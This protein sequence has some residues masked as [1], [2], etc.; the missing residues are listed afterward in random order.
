MKQRSKNWKYHRKQIYIRFVHTD[1]AK[2]AIGIAIGKA[3]IRKS[4][5]TCVSDLEICTMWADSD[6]CWLCSQRLHIEMG[7][8][9]IGIAIG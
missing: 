1:I 9:V 5:G 4:G 8:L 7:K 3:G 2:A 6:N